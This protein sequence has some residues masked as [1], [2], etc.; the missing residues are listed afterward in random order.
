MLQA[1]QHGMSLPELFSSMEEQ[2]EELG[3]DEYSMSQTTLEHVFVALAR[4]QHEQSL[5]TAS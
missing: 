1:L 4:G 5:T 3:I 2:K